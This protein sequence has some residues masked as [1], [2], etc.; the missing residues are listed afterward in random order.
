MI[1]TG[2]GGDEIFGGYLFHKIM[3]LGNTYRRM[4]PG[5]LRRWIVSPL[6]SAMP[7]GALNLLFNY[8]AHLGR[9]GKQ[10][11][12]DYHGLLEPQRISEAYCHLISLFDRRDTETLFTDDFLALMRDQ[13][14]EGSIHDNPPLDGRYLNRLVRLQFD[15]WLPDNM[16]LRQDKMGMAHAIEGRVPFLDHELVEFGMRLPPHLKIR[17]LTG[18]YILRQFGLRLL[19]K[20]VIQRKKMPFY[21]PIEHYFAEPAFQEMM[22]ELLGERSVRDRGI[23]RPEAVRDLRTKMDAKEF[24]FVKQIYSLMVLELWFRIFVDGTWKTSP[25][26]VSSAAG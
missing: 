2:E 20:E 26:T 15:H 1:L 14:K 11:V 24:L 22:E 12:V 19:P 9:R 5:P 25:D 23:F 3:S 7:V 21:V 17:R 16:L 13:A 6:L 10:K 18:K 8:P 4:V